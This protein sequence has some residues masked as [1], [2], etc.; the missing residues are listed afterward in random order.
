MVVRRR[1]ER[2]GTRVD[3]A[4]GDLGARLAVRLLGPPERTLEGGLVLA[5][6]GVGDPVEGQQVVVADE[7]DRRDGLP[8]R[9]PR[10]PELG[11]DDRG[12]GA[13]DRVDPRDGAGVGVRGL[14]GLDVLPVA[15]ELDDRTVHVRRVRGEVDELVDHLVAR[16]AVPRGEA[17]AVDQE[18]RVGARRQVGRSGRERRGA[19]VTGV[20]G[21]RAH[22]LRGGRDHGVAQ[23]VGPHR[24]G[25]PGHADEVG[26][27]GLGRDLLGLR[28]RVARDVHRRVAGRR[29][30]VLRSAGG[31][32]VPDRPSRRVAGQRLVRQGQAGLEPGGRGRPQAVELEQAQV[33][34]HVNGVER[35]HDPRPTRRRRDPVV[36][37]VR[38]AAGRGGDGDPRVRA[39]AEVAEVHGVGLD[40]RRVARGV[41]AGRGDDGEAGPELVAQEVIPAARPADGAPDR[42]TVLQGVRGGGER[43]VEERRTAV[44]PQPALGADH[45]Q[46]PRDD[47]AE[48]DLGRVGPVGHRRDRPGGRPL[49]PEELHGDRADGAG[50]GHL[51]LHASVAEDVGDTRVVEG[52]RGTG[53]RELGPL[54]WHQ[55]PRAVLGPAEVDPVQRDVLPRVVVRVDQRAEQRAEGHRGGSARGQV[56][57]HGARSDGGWSLGRGRAEGVGARAGAGQGG[58]VDHGAQ[59]RCAEGRQPDLAERRTGE[60]QVPHRDDRQQRAAGRDGAERNVRQGGAGQVDAAGVEGHHGRVGVEPLAVLQVG[61]GEALDLGRLAPRRQPSGGAVGRAGEADVRDLRLAEH[62][63]GHRQASDD[64]P[65]EVEVVVPETAD[66]LGRRGAGVGLDPVHDLTDGELL[67]RA[68]L[69]QTG[70]GEH[71][72]PAAGREQRVRRQRAGVRERPGVAE[73]ARV[74]ERP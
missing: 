15:V 65:L 35:D 20:S 24:G 55:V 70:P 63:A 34:V 25:V 11:V 73:R 36:V 13:G 46:R 37:D 23:V 3:G 45:Q 67:D 57:D 64:R 72:R 16:G 71:R 30:H 54:I 62:D 14:P 47:V 53:G 43:G 6:H 60:E 8:G 22:G 74:R 41:A 7:G 17:R 50:R 1:R 51:E 18:Q 40:D 28:A 66:L 44:E 26:P 33:G 12:G 58:A 19:R 4:D 29:L 69:E 5:L 32:F 2:R 42:L 61:T 59:R 49:G 9:G 52:V 27:V 38:C 56:R 10:R 68:A 48:V 39:E 31:G 21:T